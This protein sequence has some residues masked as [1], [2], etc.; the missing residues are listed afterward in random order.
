MTASNKLTIV[1]NKTLA[2]NKQAVYKVS[3]FSTVPV[4]KCV[5]MKMNN[6]Q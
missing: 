4:S 1:N 6:N 5:T 3:T 2:S